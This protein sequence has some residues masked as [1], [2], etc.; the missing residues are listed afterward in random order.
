L[1][2]GILKIQILAVLSHK[3]H[4]LIAFFFREAEDS[5][6]NGQGF[7]GVGGQAVI[8]VKLDEIAHLILFGFGG[9]S[10]WLLLLPILAVGTVTHKVALFATFVAMAF[11]SILFLF[12]VRRSLAYYGARV[13]AVLVVGPELW[14]RCCRTSLS[15][16][17]ASLVVVVP[18]VAVAA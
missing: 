9:S 12:F 11:L 18:V 13:H 3:V 7:G 5:S 1:C 2:S 14:P 4:E 17:L 16:L 15:L 8:V 10:M 6:R